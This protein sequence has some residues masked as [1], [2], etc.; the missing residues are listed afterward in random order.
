MVF[1][2]RKHV[3]QQCIRFL[4]LVKLWGQADLFCGSSERKLVVA[5]GGGGMG[6][7]VSEHKVF[8]KEMMEGVPQT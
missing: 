5:R 8:S 1:V 6:V 3:S 7:T 2:A 4:V